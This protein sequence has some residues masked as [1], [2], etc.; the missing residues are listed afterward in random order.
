LAVET[1][2]DESRIRVVVGDEI[3]ITD[4]GGGGVNCI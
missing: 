2:D 1:D 4:D 3:F